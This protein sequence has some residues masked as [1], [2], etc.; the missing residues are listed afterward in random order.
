M[1]IKVGNV[2]SF[3]PKSYWSK[4]GHCLTGKVTSIS[5]WDDDGEPLSNE[6]HGSIEIEITEGNWGSVGGLEHFVYFNWEETLVIVG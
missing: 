6:N 4:K 5:K 2:V 3:N 1:T